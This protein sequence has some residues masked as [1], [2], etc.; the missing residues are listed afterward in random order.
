[1]EG[2][3]FTETDFILELE[4]YDIVCQLNR[5]ERYKHEHKIH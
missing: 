3:G 5:P 2:E 4:L 1:M